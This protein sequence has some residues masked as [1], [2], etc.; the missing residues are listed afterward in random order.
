MAVARAGP[1]TQSAPHGTAA[2]EPRAD[3]PTETTPQPLPPVPPLA[4]SVALRAMPLMSDSDAELALLERAQTALLAR[5]SVAL[6]LADEDARRF[7]LGL[8]RPVAEVIAID[9]LVR[10]SRHDAAVARARLFRTM[11][12]RSPHCARVDAILARIE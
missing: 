3:A 4:A 10:T 11:F 9:A 8:L 5:P 7:P 2:A 6:E 12:P 1:P